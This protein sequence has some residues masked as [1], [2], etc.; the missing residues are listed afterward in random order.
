[1]ALSRKGFCCAGYEAGC[2]TFWVADTEGEKPAGVEGDLCFVKAG[3]GKFYSRGASG[4][5]AGAGEQ[6]PPGPEGPEGPPGEDG[7]QGPQGQQGIQGI[8]GVQGP[9]GPG[10]LWRVAASW[11]VA[12]TMTNIGTAFVDLVLGLNGGRQSVDFTGYTE[13]RVVGHW[14][15]IGGSI[16]TVRVVDA[17]NVNNVLAE[18]AMSSGVGEKEFDSGWV[19]KPAWAV[20]EKWLKPQGKAATGAD[21]PVFRD[22]QV[23]VR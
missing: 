14:N 1:M 13:I 19:A 8:Q 5:V 20:G 11:S 23:L 3:G 21:D 17:T 18:I 7:A 9:P 12:R 16:H 6:G 10:A 4:W 2:N 22:C 15:D